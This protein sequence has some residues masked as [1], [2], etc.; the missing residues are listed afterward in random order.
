MK[1]YQT[2][3]SLL[4]FCGMLAAC[5][6]DDW[7]DDVSALQHPVPSSIVMLDEAGGTIVKGNSFQ[8]RFR[9]NP[10]SVVL[11]KD[12][13]QLDVQDSDTYFRFDKTDVSDTRASYV[14]PSDYYT[15][16]NVEPA[17]NEN[18]EV[19]EGQWVA[20]VRTQGEANF[21]NVSDLHLV[22]NYTDAAGVAQQ[23]SSSG[24][25]IEIVPTVDEGVNFGYA[26]VQNLLNSKGAVTPYILFVDVN[27]YKNSL[28]VE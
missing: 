28:G 13:V 24:V 2:A 18:G 10:S 3:F 26:T 7:K 20:T 23:V 15:L 11:T 25:P 5:S 1:L 22:V 16:E 21:R 19:L 17:K 12:D 8:L 9:V 27:A 14:T 6:D 4:A